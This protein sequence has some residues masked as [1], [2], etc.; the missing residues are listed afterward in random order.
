MSLKYNCSQILLK[1]KATTPMDLSLSTESQDD[2]V[3]ELDHSGSQEKGG[4]DSS[5]MVTDNSFDADPNASV[6]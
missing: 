4:L 6:S 1:Q 3:E 2:G 5:D